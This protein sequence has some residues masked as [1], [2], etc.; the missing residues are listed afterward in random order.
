MNTAKPNQTIYPTVVLERRRKRNEKNWYIFYTSPRAEKIVYSDLL[1]R[2]Y[3]AFLPLTRTLKVWKNRQKKLIESPLFPGYIFVNTK[4]SEIYDISRLPK[5]ATYIKCG[6]NPSVISPN[7]INTIKKMLLLE[8][9]VSV[10]TT[11]YEGEQVKI[12][13]GPLTGH[14][15]ILVEQKGKTRFG[16]RL[17]EINHTVFINVCTNILQKINSSNPVKER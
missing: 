17:K 10:E 11:F 9:D 5:I 3:D 15:G 16:I 6:Q 13:H 2:E 12:I 8:E 7:D 4:M 1:A 14:E